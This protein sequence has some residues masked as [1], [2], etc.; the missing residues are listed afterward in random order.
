MMNAR[1]GFEE[2]EHTADWALRVW[3]IDLSGLLCQAVAGMFQLMGTV[4]GDQAHVVDIE[5]SGI[6]AETLLVNF[7]SEI[8]LLGEDEGLMIAPF[9]PDVEGFRI[10]S[11]VPAFKIERQEKEIKAVT[12][13]HLEVKNVSGGIETTIVFDV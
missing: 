5:A 10:R 1:S 8:L 4:A 3:A 6:D 12:F 9:E 2:L 7:L 11:K 13:H